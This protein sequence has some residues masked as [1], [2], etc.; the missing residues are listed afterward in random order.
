VEKIVIAGAGAHCKV[1][2]DILRSCGGFEPVG[3]LDSG[4]RKELL[5]VP[6][7]GT[8]NLLRELRS[9]GVRYG[10]AAIGSNH[11]RERVSAEM[12]EAGFTLAT[13]VSPYAVVSPYAQIGAGTAVM[14]GAVVNACA[15]IGRGCILNTNCS[16]DHDCEMGDFVH[17]APGCAVSGSVL[18]GHGSF[19]GTGAR[20]IDGINIG[21]RVMVGAG[22]AVI[23]DLPDGCTAVGV[24]ARIIKKEG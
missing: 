8:D 5:G 9:A 11:V 13:L 4:G 10:F 16:V 14:P 17:I 21:A 2:L 15:K 7:I 6:V 1:I 19:L 23:R 3:L 22:A 24:P 12:E 20:V 18:V